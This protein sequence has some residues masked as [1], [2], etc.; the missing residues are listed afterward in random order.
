MK[1]AGWFMM[2]D[3]NGL[4]HPEAQLCIWYE[5]ANGDGLL[6]MPIVDPAEYEDDER[7][8]CCGCPMN[9][10][11]TNSS[12]SNSSVTNIFP[13]HRMRDSLPNIFRWYVTFGG[14]DVNRLRKTGELAGFRLDGDLPN[15]IRES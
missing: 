4:F 7:S 14:P 15:A 10:S 6:Y 12:A 3:G 11:D 5:F 2:P 1:K 9:S 8:V 13:A